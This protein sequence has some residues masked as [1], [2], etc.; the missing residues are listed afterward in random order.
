MEH[1]DV[2]QFGIHDYLDYPIDEQLYGKQ[3]SRTDFERL[4]QV[5]I[6]LCLSYL[7]L[8]KPDKHTYYN[9]L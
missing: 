4:C 7:T 8:N 3:L 9:R 2:R 6:S 1:N 5:C